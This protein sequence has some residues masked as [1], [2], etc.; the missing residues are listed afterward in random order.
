MVFPAFS[1]ESNTITRMTIAVGETLLSNL[2]LSTGVHI[3][4]DDFVNVTPKTIEHSLK[5]SS[6]QW[7]KGDRFHINQIGHPYQGSTYFN[8]ARANGFNFYQSIFYSIFGSYTWEVFFENLPPSL[9]DL[10]STTVG[11]ASLGEMFHRIYLEINDTNIFAVIGSTLLSPVDRFQDT[12]INHNRSKSSGNIYG[13]SISAGFGYTNAVFNNN[14]VEKDRWDV[15]NGGISTHI[16]YGNPFSQQ[17]TVPYEH[18]ELSAGLSGLAPVWYDANIISDAYLVSFQL[19]DYD[20]LKTSTGLSLHFDFFNT[21]NDLPDNRG[22][23]NINVSANSLDWTFKNHYSISEYISFEYKKH[24]GWLAWGIG[25]YLKGSED[26]VYID[27]T[28]G[29]HVKES[30]AVIHSRWGRI[31]IDYLHFH[32]KS[33]SN[34]PQ[35][36]EGKTDFYNIRVSYS[37]PLTKSISIGIGDT[38][39]LLKSGYRNAPNIRNYS[40]CVNIFFRLNY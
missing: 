20:N 4:G 13:Y 9:N 10:V 1:E 23:S 7:E 40:N 2:T 33:I 22:F 11:G 18:F 31:D 3:Q 36:P 27:Y 17:T 35:N 24:L 8:S 16:V 25:N 21:T 30:F 19:F 12:V 14:G 29:L 37:Y 38:F 5:F 6:W 39:S 15:P 28:M 26:D 32:M 34:M